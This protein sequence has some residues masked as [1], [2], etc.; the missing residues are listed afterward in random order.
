[1][2]YYPQSGSLISSDSGAQTPT[3]SGGTHTG[4][5]T[6]VIIMVQNFPV[7]AIQNLTINQNRSLKR[8]NEIGTDGVVEIVPTTPTAVNISI[9]RIAFDGMSLP[10]AFSRVFSNIQAQR[11]PFNIDIY[12]TQGENEAFGSS[13]AGLPL[14]RRIHNCWFSRLSIPYAANN[15]IISESAEI[16]AEYITNFLPAF[17]KSLRQPWA[18]GANADTIEK[19]IDTTG[20]R[21][22]LDSISLET[23]IRSVGGSIA[24]IGRRIDNL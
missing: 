21:A 9:Q 2:A 16:M 20:R 19:E 15:Y 18:N 5:S 4:L 12:Q 17:S 6:Q 14:V 3:L 10:E 11:I 13:P 1:M 22:S 23:R 7:G 24:D 8:L